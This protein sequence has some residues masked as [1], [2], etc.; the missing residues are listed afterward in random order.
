MGGSIV[1]LQKPECGDRRIAK[2]L[3][4]PSKTLVDIG[5]PAS[6]IREMPHIGDDYPMEVVGL[7]DIELGERTDE[8]KGSPV[9][10]NA[11]LFDAQDSLDSLGF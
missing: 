4:I 7:T 6:I 5:I 2:E 3:E 10:R 8:D 11:D 1:R 9:P